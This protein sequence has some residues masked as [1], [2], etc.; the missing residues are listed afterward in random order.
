MGLI[1]AEDWYSDGDHDLG[2]AARAAWNHWPKDERLILPV[3]VD[4]PPAAAY[5]NHGRWVAECPHGCG[6][7]QVVSPNDPR[8][9]CTACRNRGGGWSPVTFPKDRDAIEAALSQRPPRNANWL[10]GEPVKRL[11]EENKTHGMEA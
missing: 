5:V 7:A 6:S 3:K 4:G 8:F 9:F 2:V 1:T 10:P 11:L